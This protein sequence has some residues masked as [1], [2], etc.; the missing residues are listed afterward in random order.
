MP[1]LR[2]VVLALL[3]GLLSAC[4]LYSVDYR[5]WNKANASDE[6]LDVALTACA[7]ESRVG[8]VVGSSDPR[9]Y[10]KGPAT[11]EQTE[12]NRLFQRCMSARGWWADQPRL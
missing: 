8:T 5:L 4:S 12:A 9:T 2:P 1:A 6:E 3:V 11:P 7:P 10:F